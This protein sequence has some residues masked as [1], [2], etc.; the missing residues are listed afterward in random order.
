MNTKQQNNDT[1]WLE[2][3]GLRRNPFPVVPDV[4]NFYV[5]DSIEEIV[6]GLVD[7]IAARKGFLLF[8]GEVGL[9][10]TTISRK[11]IKI[12]DQRGVKNSFV[13]HTFYQETELL[14]QIIR[15]FGLQA[16]GSV[17][18]DYVKAF[19]DFLLDQHRQGVNCAIIIDDAQ[20]LSHKSLELIRMLSNFETNQEK[21]VQILLVGQ[22]ELEETLNS[23]S[24][25]QLKSR[26]VI[27]RKVEPLGL[28]ALQGYIKFKLYM[29][30]GARL[31]RV[32]SNTIKKIHKQTKGDMR[33]VNILMERCLQVAFLRNITHI[34]PA[35]LSEAQRDMV[36]KM[37]NGY[38]E[39]RL[40]W[41]A[42]AASPVVGCLTGL[43]F[44]L[45]SQLNMVPD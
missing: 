2:Y 41:W 15:D 42:L 34:S 17:L 1:T 8:T 37:P 7:G 43:L 31:I 39:D 20:N 4:D 23:P 5:C 27:H 21:L 25:R 12:L 14:Q 32:P 29:A 33:Q 40:V 13:F 30:G 45:L 36:Q 10:K 35:I 16:D 26:I 3:F 44:Y 28:E 22:P 9:G 38:D 24:L 18:N 19:N 6:T 11:I